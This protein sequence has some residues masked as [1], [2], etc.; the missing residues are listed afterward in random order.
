MIR[1]ESRCLT[2]ARVFSL[3]LDVSQVLHSDLRNRDAILI[4]WEVARSLPNTKGLALRGSLSR[5]RKNLLKHHFLLKRIYP[6]LGVLRRNGDSA[7]SR[8]QGWREVME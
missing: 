6:T 1:N 4:L 2:Y 5:G 7:L 3:C 8:R